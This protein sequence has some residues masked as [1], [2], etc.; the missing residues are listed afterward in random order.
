MA[1]DGPFLARPRCGPSVQVP[2]REKQSYPPASRQMRG[3]QKENPADFIFAVRCSA[4]YDYSEG[5]AG[6]RDWRTNDDFNF[7]WWSA[8]GQWHE[9]PIT[10][11]L[12]PGHVRLE[13]VEM[14]EPIDS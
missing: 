10:Y 1:L 12:V 14:C 4:I 9:V 11:F 3:S 6:V 2:S 8:D 13:R 5:D 7:G